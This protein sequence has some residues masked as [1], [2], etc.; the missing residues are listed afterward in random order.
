MVLDANERLG[1]HQ[2]LWSH[3]N[4]RLCVPAYQPST[5]PL[6]KH[7]ASCLSK[8]GLPGHLELPTARDSKRSGA[9]CLETVF[10]SKQL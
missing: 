1:L 4:Q 9:S 2:F 7:L 5:G 3:A 8:N 10:G 6:G